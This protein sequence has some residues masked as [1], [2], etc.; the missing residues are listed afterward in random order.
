MLRFTCVSLLQVIYTQP[1][2]GLTVR[3]E[4]FTIDRGMPWEDALQRY[5]QEVGDSV[6][7]RHN[8]QWTA[9]CLCQCSL[10]CPQGMTGPCLLHSCFWVMKLRHSTIFDEA[11]VLA[12]GCVPA[13]FLHTTLHPASISWLH[14]GRKF[15]ISP[16]INLLLCLQLRTDPDTR[17]GFWWRTHGNTGRRQN[18]LVSTAYVVPMLTMWLAS[19]SSE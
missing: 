16:E 8:N 3:H 5:Q 17:S 6:G 15:N 1:H 7:G 10:Q 4:Q 18:V 11:Q 13:I 9:I 12:Q 14:Q 19:C 2:S